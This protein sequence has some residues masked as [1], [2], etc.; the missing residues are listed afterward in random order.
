MEE[1]ILMAAALEMNQRGI[2]FTLDHVATQVG[3]SKKT[4]YQYYPSK[5][6]LISKIIDMALEDVLNQETTILEDEKRDFVEKLQDL[7]MLNPKRFGKPNDWVMEDIKRYCIEEW[8]RIEEFK[9]GR[10]LA[11]SQLLEEGITLGMVRKI[12]TKVAA[13]LLIGACKELQQYEFL[14]EN[15]MDSM[16]VRQLLTDI[17]MRGILTEKSAIRNAESSKTNG[18]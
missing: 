3:I 1:K 9:Y 7:M 5:D 15:N 17:F 13:R 16:Q 4:I 12:N 10:M 2:K 6:V 8:K 18:G 11:I 14:V